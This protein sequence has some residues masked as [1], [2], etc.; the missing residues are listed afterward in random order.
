[1]GELVGGPPVLDIS[2]PNIHDSKRDLSEEK[3]AVEAAM[4]SIR[5]LIL[6][7]FPRQ[8][9]EENQKAHLLAK[10]LRTHL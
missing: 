5:S 10:R 1:M 2:K 8:P 7:L 6:L 9:E 4:A 3:E